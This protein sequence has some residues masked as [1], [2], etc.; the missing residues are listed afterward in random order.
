MKLFEGFSIRKIF[1]SL[2]VNNDRSRDQIF[3]LPF[4]FLDLC[5]YQNVLKRSKDFDLSLE[6]WEQ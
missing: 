5:F 6:V 4:F 2:P 1:N 3:G